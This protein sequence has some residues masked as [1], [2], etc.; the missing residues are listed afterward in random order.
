ML[1]N[2]L[3]GRRERL[4]HRGDPTSHDYPGKVKNEYANVIHS[5]LGV[6]THNQLTI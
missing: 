4:L 2:V 5:E 3:P 1:R 6:E